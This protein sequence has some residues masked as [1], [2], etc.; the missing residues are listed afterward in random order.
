MKIYT[1]YF[2]QVRFFK[3]NYLG[4]STALSDPKWFHDFRR[5]PYTFID[6]NG[7][8][9]GLRADPFVPGPLCKN[10]CHGIIGCPYAHKDKDNWCP[11]LQRYYQQLGELSIPKIVNCFQKLADSI[12]MN[13]GFQ[14]EPKIIL[15]LHEAPQNPCSERWPLQKWL[16]DFGLFAGE[17]II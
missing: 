7:V 16:T 15:L 12:Q 1:S 6:K 11:F 9:N 13:V 3:P 8:L 2:Y 14:E 4:F 17:L 10:L 5:P